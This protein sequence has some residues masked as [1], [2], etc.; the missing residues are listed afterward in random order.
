MNID[1]LNIPDLDAGLHDLLESKRRVTPQHTNRISAMDDPC[2][3]RLYYRRRAWSHATPHPTSLLGVF[4]TGNVLEPVISRIASEVGERSRP[5]WRIVG[6]QM[7]VND[8]L[9]RDYQISGTIDG[10]LQ[11]ETPVDH[12]MNTPDAVQ[13]TRWKNAAVLDAKTMSG[14]IYPRINSYNDLARYSWTRSYRGQ[15][16]LYALAFNLEH[17]TILATN[18]QNLYEMKFI[19]WKIDYEYLEGLLQKAKTVN[20]AIEAREPPEGVN[21]P[22]VCECCQWLAYCCPDLVPTGN[23]KILDNDELEAILE[24]MAELSEAAGEYRDLEKQRD[25]MLTKG[26]DIAVGRFLITWKQS[27]NGAW[28]KH[29]MRQALAAAE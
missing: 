12:P 21:Q 7:P 11:V 18:K 19:S 1:I 27:S 2:L 3:R 10:I 15:L 23:L 24:R 4:E 5:R 20:E 13:V 9:F 22:T 8:K 26:Q 29:I 28:R 6:N 25:Y 17:C 16:G 14:N